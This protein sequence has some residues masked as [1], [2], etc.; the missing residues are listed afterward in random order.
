ME[1]VSGPH[2]AGT[3]HYQD[4][5]FIT[6]FHR[7]PAAG[8]MARDQTG[9][10]QASNNAFQQLFGWHPRNLNGQREAKFPLWVDAVEREQWLSRLATGESPI[11]AESSLRCRDGHLIA[12]RITIELITLGDQ[13]HRLYLFE[14]IA[15]LATQTAN[16]GIL[17]DYDSL[18]LALDASQM[19]IWELD[20]RT[21]TL[22]ASAHSAALHGFTADAWRGALRT[23]MTAVPVIDQRALRRAFLTIC[24]GRRSRHKLTYR[25]T[26]AD[27]SIKWLEAT[28]R[29]DRDAK[30]TPVRLTGTLLDITE[31]R[32]S[33]QAVAESHRK[34]S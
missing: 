17:P 25:V 15:P 33:E 34:F 26:Q 14:P 20:T 5:A 31:R 22:N 9:T 1:H 6:L 29:I 32:R 21:A 11:L 18:G 27:G 24:R 23:F 10:I 19:G 13:R 16:T 3:G 12:C 30:D 4:D 7:M 8:L 28:A 2:V